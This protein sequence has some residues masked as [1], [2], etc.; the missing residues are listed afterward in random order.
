MDALCIGVGQRA[1]AEAYYQLALMAKD[2]GDLSG[3]QIDASM[4]V[5]L[6][7]SNPTYAKLDRDLGIGSKK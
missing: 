6:D 7:D 1:A 2:Q 5:L 3:A 4:A